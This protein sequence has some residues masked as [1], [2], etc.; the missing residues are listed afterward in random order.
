MSYRY[1]IGEDTE[2]EIR[3]IIQERFSRSMEELKNGETGADIANHQM[4]KNM[5]KARAA[6]RLVRDSTGE[7]NYKTWNVEARDIAR[8]GE[9]LRESYVMLE[10]LDKL[11]VRFD[12]KINHGFYKIVR[13]KLEQ[14]YQDL[15][16]H[17]LEEENLP[18]QLSERLEDAK[19]EMQELSF[20]EKGFRA[21]KKGLKRV[22]KRGRKAAVKARKKLTSENHHEWRK[23][24]KYL[25]YHIRILKDTWPAG[26]KGYAKE[27]HNLSDLLG[28]DHDLFDLRAKLYEDFNTPE[29]K[30]ELKEL[31]ALIHKMSREKRTK[32]WQL[33][34]KIYAEKPKQFIKR[35]QTYWKSA[36]SA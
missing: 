12:W 19:E 9:D 15:R 34:E 32:A 30:V 6:L 3:R 10:T 11:K 24:V 13:R 1:T 35:M 27:L 7:D 23:R 33:G 29:Y 26:L 5:K 2:K 28:D 16:K 22:Y 4:R 21:F 25:W 17:L 36:Q 8:M 31:D 18:Q 14:D 20:N